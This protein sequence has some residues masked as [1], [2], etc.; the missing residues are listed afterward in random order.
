MI[1]LLTLAF[2]PIAFVCFL[3][4]FLCGGATAFRLCDRP[5][6]PDQEPI[7]EYLERLYQSSK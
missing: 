4:G 2:I 6:P 5:Q 3:L 7:R 1:A